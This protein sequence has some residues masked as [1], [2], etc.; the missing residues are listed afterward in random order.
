MPDLG[1]LGGGFGG[2]GEKELIFD[3]YIEAA[4]GNSKMY[5]ELCFKDI[6]GWTNFFGKSDRGKSYSEIFGKPSCVAFFPGVYTA[7]GTDKSDIIVRN[8]QE[9][10]AYVL[11]LGEM[12][13]RYK[14]VKAIE[15][16]ANGEYLMAG[17]T[18]GPVI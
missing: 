5:E 1:A 15:F 16:S 3:D 6:R 9:R 8:L 10:G 12:K 13:N 4:K 11:G 14:S 18:M 17:Y 7:L 2:D